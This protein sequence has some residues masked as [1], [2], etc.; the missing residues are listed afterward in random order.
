ML[1]N[2]KYLHNWVPGEYILSEE[3][4]GEFL[5]IYNLVNGSINTDNIMPGAIDGTSLRDGSIGDNHI[6]SMNASKLTG[7]IS[8]DLLPSDL[9]KTN[10]AVIQGTLTFEVDSSTPIIKNYEFEETT[11][12]EGGTGD[13]KVRLV[14]GGDAAMKVFYGENLLWKLNLDGIEEPVKFKLPVA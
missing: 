11:L 5:N 10:G 1:I 2:S 14:L 9:L 13:N 8:S 4:K 7:V 12:F 6:V 3:V